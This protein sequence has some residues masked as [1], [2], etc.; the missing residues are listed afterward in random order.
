[1]AGF[2]VLNADNAIIMG[3]DPERAII[4]S[5][6]IVDA[7]AMSR[8][9]AAK[10]PPAPAYGIWCWPRWLPCRCSMSHEP[11]RAWRS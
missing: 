7:P 1:M 6:M 3:F 8:L 10:T 4:L 2:D 11:R 5:W 9:L